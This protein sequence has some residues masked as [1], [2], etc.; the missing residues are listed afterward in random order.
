MV[1]SRA[2]TVTDKEE[3]GITFWL[4]E[5]VTDAL[6]AVFNLFSLS[7]LVILSVE[8]GT[9]TGELVSLGTIFLC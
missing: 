7:D 9:A 5:L 4:G 2:L 6:R 3:K 1:R 8:V